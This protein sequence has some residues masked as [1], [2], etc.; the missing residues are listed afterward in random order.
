MNGKRV[1]VTGMGLVS[2]LGHAIDEFWDN[3]VNG[4]SGVGPLTRTDPEPHAT[5]IAAEVK[6]FDPLTYME[7]KQARHMDLFTQFAVVAADKAIQ[8]SGIDFS[9]VN[10]ELV[11]AIIASGIGG[12]NTFGEQLE[13]FR[14]SGAKKVSPFFIPKLIP[15]ISPGYIAIKYGLKGINYCTVSACA[16]ASHALGEAFN[17]I[18]YGKAISMV[19]GGSEAPLT[20]MGVAGFNALKAISTRND[21]PEKASRPFDADRD[22]FVMGEGGAILVLEELEHAKNRGANIYGEISGVGFTCDAYHI[23]APDPDGDGA[24][25]AMK[26]AMQDAEID[27]KDV[28][29][30]NAHGTS[31]PPNDRVETTAIK[32]IFGDRAKKLAISSTKSMVGHML[33]ASG[34]IEAM[35]TVLS[36]KHGL[37]HPTINYEKPDP[38]CDLDYI[39]NT[40]REM[41]VKCALSNS[42][43]FGGH[44]ACIAF[45]KYTG[46]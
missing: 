26:I 15:D 4:K 40:A 42:F 19:A 27:P 14:K 41:D 32:T 8:D 37:F 43:G 45:K 30:I 6:N 20:G 33:G 13:L 36:L 18:H 22:G 9:K 23:T 21:E 3:L 7:R 29:Y 1:V 2:P 44:N 38:E 10:T 25:R 5:K 28:G 17:A 12:M 46:D 35:A 11:G 16:S 34:A 24:A 31:T 39:P